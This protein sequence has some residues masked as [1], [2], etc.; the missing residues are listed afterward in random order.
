MAKAIDLT[1]QRFGKLV[2]MKR[3]EGLKRKDTQWLCRCECGNETIVCG[4]NLRY[5]KTKSC[6]C[7]KSAFKD[8]TGKRFGRLVV[9]ERVENNKN[10][11]ARWRCV[12]DCGR[13]AVSTTSMLNSGHNV[14]CGC[15][16]KHD[17]TGKRFGLLE[18]VSQSPNVGKKT[19]WECKC[20]C[21]QIAFCTTGNLVGGLSKS[22]GCV[23]TKHMGK[24]TRLY[25]I[26]TGMKDRCLNP[27]SKYWDRYGGRGVSIYQPWLDDFAVFRDWALT[28]GYEETLTIDRENN[29][30]NYEPGNCQWLTLVENATKGNR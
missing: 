29:D 26:W 18:V 27:K 7:L 14:S 17:L 1:G 13:E 10:G 11:G 20:D 25:R 4:G 6:G 2:V 16:A 19:A 5:G 8:L 9:L 21:G 15:A 28:N 12:C 22:C 24:G 23:R 3:V 30:G